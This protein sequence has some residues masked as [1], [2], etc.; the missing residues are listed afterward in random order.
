[1]TVPQEENVVKRRNQICFF[2][3]VMVFPLPAFSAF[4][5]KALTAR[6]AGMGESLTAATG[7][8]NGIL[9][10][11]A[12][13]RFLKGLEVSSGYTRLFH[14]SDLVHHALAFGLNTDRLG[15]WGFSYR[16]FGPSVFQEKEL[17]LSHSVFLF[18]NAALGYSLKSSHLQMKRY[19]SSS[20]WGIDIGLLGRIHPLCDMGVSVQNINHPRFQGI[21]EGPE[22][23]MRAG[24]GFYLFQGF[25]TC[26]D[27]VKSVNSDMSY[28]AGQEIS[29]G[30]VLQL[31]FGIQTKPNRYS[32]GIGFGV[33]MLAIDY[34]FLTHPY[35]EDQH[36]VSLSMKW[37]GVVPEKR[38]EIGQKETLFLDKI[39]INKARSDELERLPGIG[40]VMAQKIIDYREKNGSFREVIGL[41]NI[42]RF[43]K[44]LFLK[45]YPL[46]TVSPVQ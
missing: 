27:M 28:R 24:F 7:D 39:D 19:G 11:P 40:P 23:T 10:N 17:T 22:Q 1:M 15:A 29:L 30:Q 46:I 45:V 38:Q 34:A 25:I 12:N 33:K 31:R 4:E 26:L 14:M 9:Y 2:M 41:L 36:H 6:A 32:A 16:Q 44:N 35:L 3:V 20:A 13:L 42:P 43:H 8:V 18:S 21:P 5:E 37:P